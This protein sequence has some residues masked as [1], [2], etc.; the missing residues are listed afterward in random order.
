[1]RGSDT[2]RSVNRVVWEHEAIAWSGVGVPR[3]D[4]RLERR[5]LYVVEDPFSAAVG[6]VNPAA[7]ES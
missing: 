5:V 3:K 7:S 6:H 1:M 4:H 2:G